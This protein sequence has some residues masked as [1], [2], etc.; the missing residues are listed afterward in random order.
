MVN[1]VRTEQSACWKQTAAASRL[2]P[3]VIDRLVGCFFAFFFLFCVYVSC[4]NVFVCTVCML[5]VRRG[6]K[7]ALDPLGLELQLVM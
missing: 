7:I 5:G 4:L 6:K 1:L 3:A 2:L